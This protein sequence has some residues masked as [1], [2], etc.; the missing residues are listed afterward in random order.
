M[1]VTFA[2][3]SEGE[4]DVVAGESTVPGVEIALGHGEGVSE[5]EGAVHVGVGEG[6]EILGL[7]VGFSHKILMP[8][9]DVLGP[10][11]QRYEFVS[12]GGVLHCFSY[13]AK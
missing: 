1:R 5:V 3:E 12:A 4:E 2:V 7:V 6:L 8:F 13:G 11:L 10:L 9:P